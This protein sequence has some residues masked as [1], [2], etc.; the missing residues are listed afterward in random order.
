MQSRE[1]DTPA[2]NANERNE[3]VTSP[4]TDEVKGRIKEAVGALTDNDDLKSDGKHE[5]VAASAKQAVDK[6]RDKVNEGIEA[7]KETLHKS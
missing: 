1:G 6:A 2:P 3:T 7:L 4:K 5:Q